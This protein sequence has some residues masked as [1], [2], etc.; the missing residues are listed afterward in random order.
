VLYEGTATGGSVNDAINSVVT[1]YATA[2][3]QNS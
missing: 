2:H 1:A 3:P